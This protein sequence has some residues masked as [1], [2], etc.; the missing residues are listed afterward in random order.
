MLRNYC[1]HK[2][3]KLV[4]VAVNFGGILY[5]PVFAIECIIPKT[6]FFLTFQLIFEKKNMFLKLGS[7]GIF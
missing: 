2:F 3:H 6:M 4:S 5:E 7:S 1:A